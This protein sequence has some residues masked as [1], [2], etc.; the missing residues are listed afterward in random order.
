[1]ETFF[2]ILILVVIILIFAIPILIICAGATV[3]ALLEM[4]F[5]YVLGF[6]LCIVGLVILT[7]IISLIK[8]FFFSPAAI[9]MRKQRRHRRKLRRR[10]KRN[11]RKFIKFN[12]KK[13][14]SKR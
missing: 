2:Y 9:E 13:K 4:A 8:E 11:I 12:E 5:P 7:A 10:A 1:M 3:Y 14:R 6:I